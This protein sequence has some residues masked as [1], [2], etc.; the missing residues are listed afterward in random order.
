MYERAYSF[1]ESRLP[2]ENDFKWEDVEDSLLTAMNKDELAIVLMLSK[3]KHQDS[4][5]QREV[6]VAISYF[7]AYDQTLLIKPLKWLLINIERFYQLSI[8]SI[9]ELLLVEK[10]HCYQI[11]TSIEVELLQTSNIENLYIKNTIIDLLEGINN[12]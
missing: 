6:L 8:A 10:E 12:G 9:L 2:D 5:I 11:L 7:I 4:Q 1:I 3:T